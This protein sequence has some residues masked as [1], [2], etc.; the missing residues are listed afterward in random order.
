MAIDT[1]KEVFFLPMVG[2]GQRFSVHHAPAGGAAVVGLVV[3]VHPF[4]EEMNK[5]RRMAALQSRA[6]AR[7]GFA[8]LQVD[9]LGCG[10]SSGDFGDA[11]WDDWVDDIVAASRWMLQR[12]DAPLT[13]WGLRSGCLLAVQAAKRLQMPVDFLL[14]QPL[15]AGTAVLQQFLRLELAVKIQAGSGK[16]VL[17]GLRATLANGEAVDVAGYRLAA[18]LATGLEQATLEPTPHAG[19]VTWLEV[20]GQVDATLLPASASAVE[21]WRKAGHQVESRVAHGPPFWHS[22]EV[23]EAPALIEATIASMTAAVPA[24]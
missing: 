15:T 10:D 7:A 3:Y 20:S 13:L 24:C 2:R 4:A 19:H 1:T 11:T 21:R 5:S 16:G 22:V 14:W 12:Y 9:L 6:L 18:S 17:D 8:V 23:E